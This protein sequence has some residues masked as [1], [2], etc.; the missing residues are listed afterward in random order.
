MSTENNKASRDWNTVDGITFP[1]LSWQERVRLTCSVVNT[2]KV[3]SSYFKHFF[4]QK[5]ALFVMEVNRMEGTVASDLVNPMT[6]SKVVSYLAELCEPPNVIAWESRGRGKQRAKSSEQQLYQF[7]RAVRY[8]IIVNRDAPLSLELFEKTNEIMMA[9]SYTKANNRRAATDTGT[10]GNACG[11][12]SLQVN[13]RSVA[14]LR[15]RLTHICE[16][17][18]QD[19]V[20]CH[21]ITMATYLHHEMISIPIFS[22]GNGRMSHLFLAWSLLN[23]GFPFPVALRVG[24]GKY[25]K[26][27][28][29][30]S[31]SSRDEIYG[32]LNAMC[33]ASMESVCGNYIT[34][35]KLMQMS[36]NGT[37]DTLL[38]SNDN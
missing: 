37:A 18:N 9:N 4:D 6:H 23:D 33:L 35:V 30:E 3:D 7:C 27:F 21:P 5:L 31:R 24:R 34:N 14:A 16:I 25:D 29:D 13:P 32:K 12:L 2:I 26:R 17:Y 19:R 38:E 11:S 20:N 1:S 8:L 22:H 36:S 15:L 10:G 28:F